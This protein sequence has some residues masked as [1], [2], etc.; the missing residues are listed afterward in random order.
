[1]YQIF[2][3]YI[4]LET[5]LLQSLT[6]TAGARNPVS[7][8]AALIQQRRLAGVAAISMRSTCGCGNLGVASHAWVVCQLRRLQRG[9][10][11]T[12]MKATSVQ[13]RLGGGARQIE[14]DSK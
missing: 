8:W 14:P 1:M 13:W 6:C 5:Q 12:G 2:R 10:K 11:P 4:W 9:C 3:R 7:R